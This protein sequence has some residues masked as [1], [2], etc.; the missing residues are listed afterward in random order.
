MD[1]ITITKDQLARVLTKW[2]KSV[3]ANPTA[4][5]TDAEADALPAEQIG[6]ESADYLFTLLADSAA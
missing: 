2:E 6:Q 5:R 3:R 4:F 1:T